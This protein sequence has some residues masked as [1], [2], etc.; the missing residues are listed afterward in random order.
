[1]RLNFLVPELPCSELSRGSGDAIRSW[2][3]CCGFTFTRESVPHKLDV[4]TSRI[5]AGRHGIA[6]ELVTNGSLAG[7]TATTPLPP[8]TYVGTTLKI[9]TKQIVRVELK[10]SENPPFLPSWVEKVSLGRDDVSPSLFFPLDS[11]PFHRQASLLIFANKSS[12]PRIH[13]LH[14]FVL[15]CH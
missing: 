12:S 6:C 14:Q 2:G 11:F 10:T 4:P 9:S 15:F 5:A 8:P 3:A 1:M 13:H 7:R